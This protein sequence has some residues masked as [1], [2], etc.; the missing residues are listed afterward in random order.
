MKKIAKYLLFAMLLMSVNSFSYEFHENP[1]QLVYEL[2][3]EI[4][5]IGEKYEVL[6]D[7]KHKQLNHINQSLAEAYSTEQKVELLY[8][9]DK[10]NAEIKQ[11]SIDTNTE[12]SKIRYLK[13]L[14]IIKI[15]YE[16][17]LSLD[18]KNVV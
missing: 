4:K 1:N 14:Q 7:E 10:I 16:K 8:Q 15:L 9:K 18:R 5:K 2:L 3:H 11:L 13:G 6:L 12:I 17:V